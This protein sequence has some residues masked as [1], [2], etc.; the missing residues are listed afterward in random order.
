MAGDDDAPAQSGQGAASSAVGELMRQAEELRA[1][2][3]ISV[4]ELEGRIEIARAELAQRREHERELEARCRRMQAASAESTEK[5]AQQCKQTRAD[6][7]ASVNRLSRQLRTREQEAAAAAIA[8]EDA[9][10]AAGAAEAQKKQANE[11][12]R[13]V[14]LELQRRNTELKTSRS[15]ASSLRRRVEELEREL[16][17]C[18]WNSTPAPDRSHAGVSEGEGASWPSPF[19]GDPDLEAAG[20]SAE[21]PAHPSSSLAAEEGAAAETPTKAAGRR[22]S[23][24]TAAFPAWDDI[25]VPDDLLRMQDEFIARIVN[26]EQRT[27]RASRAAAA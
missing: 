8:V 23:G 14:T 27:L 6:S 22:P 21:D 25:P 5:M 1:M 12:A 10:A 18:R 4:L 2:R 20:S 17:V 11:V 7:A 26:I 16:E 3:G 9:T 15:E 13:A 19:L 24:P